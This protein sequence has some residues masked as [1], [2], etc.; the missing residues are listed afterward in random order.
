M[1]V[2]PRFFAQPLRFVLACLLIPGSLAAQGGDG[3]DGW[4][5]PRVLELVEAARVVRQ[6]SAVDTA[7]TSYQ[8]RAQGFVY[9]FLDRPDEEEHTLIKAD[10]IALDVFWRAPGLTRQRIVGLRDEKVLPTNIRYHLDHLTVVQ[11]DF[12]DLIRMGDGDEVAA[13][14]HPAAPGAETVYRYRLADSLSLAYAGLS[15]PVRVYEVQVRPRDLERPGFVGALYLDRASGAIVRMAFTFTPASYVDPYLDYIR[16]SLDNALWMGR[17]WL[18][19]RQEVELRRELPQLD[20]MAGS[21]IRGRWE[22]GDYR[23]NEEI[24]DFYFSGPRVTAAAERLR[25]DFLFPDDLYADLDREGLAPSPSLDEIQ[26]QVRSMALAGALQ[27]LRPLRLYFSS[28][29]D[30]VR[31]NRAEGWAFGLG[32]TL[33]AGERPVR[34]VGGYSTAAR[35]GWA[36]GEMTIPASFGSFAIEGHWNRL[37]DMGPVRGASGVVNTL[38][39]L[40]GRDYLDPYWSTG[41]SATVTYRVSPS[42]RLELGALLEDHESSALEVDD[43]NTVFRAVRPV[44]PGTLA[45]GQVALVWPDGGNGMF[46]RAGVRVGELGEAYARVDASVGWSRRGG[47]TELDRSVELQGGWATSKAPLQELYLLGGRATIPGY[48]YRGAVGDRYLLARGWIRAS[49]LEPWVSLRLTGAAGWSRLGDRQ[50]PTEW[51]S[52]TRPGWRSSVGVGVDLLWEVL[53]FD[54]ARGLSHGGDW[55]F[56][57]SVSPRLTPWL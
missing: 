8:S 2:P 57:F 26:D 3:P 20:F 29:S 30:A 6:S 47:F 34:I 51:G 22:V 18:P 11:D 13:V 5:Q 1:S 53:Q 39:T 35:R 38:A 42:T 44:D 43:Q 36:R 49:L 10:Q 48:E 14:L 4:D 27:G 37:T 15:E 25:E 56:F 16:I 9:F 21:I 46:G 45:A 40:G 54:V 33:R 17:H 28:V 55:S 41:G 24:P 50:L 32:A 19:Y 12:Q 52:D 31:R 7:F 23:F